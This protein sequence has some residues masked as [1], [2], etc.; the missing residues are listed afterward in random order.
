MIKYKILALMFCIFSC[1][2]NQDSDCANS[3]EYTITDFTGLD[4]CQLLLVDSDGERF[5]A[6][7][8]FEMI[9]EAKNGQKIKANISANFD[10]VSICMAG[11]IVTINCIES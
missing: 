11:E 10:V 5:E 3:K 9:P 6:I 4:G 1:N 7:N 2:K 8:L